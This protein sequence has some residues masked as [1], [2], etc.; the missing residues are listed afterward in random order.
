[1]FTY[2][3]LENF[4]SFGKIRFDFK[5]N[6]NECKKFAAI[7]GE[8]GSGKSNFVSAY[9]LL[10]M[11]M[12]SY[13]NKERKLKALQ[14]LST[15]SSRSSNFLNKVLLQ[16]INIDD[17]DVNF[18]KYRMLGCSENT[19]IKYGFIIN[20]VEGYYS[21][22][23]DDYSILKEEL[24]YI[25]NKQRG[26]LFDIK[27]CGEE[28]NSHISK[29]LF[30]DSKLEE[31]IFKN[32]EMY[33]GKNTLLALLIKEK[34]DKNPEY[35]N[36]NISKNLISVVNFFMHIYI[37]C[38]PSP[39]SRTN[40]I[41][42]SN[43]KIRDLSKVYIEPQNEKQKKYLKK[44]EKI[45]KDFFTQAY[46][47]IIDVYYDMN[48][49]NQDDEDMYEYVPYVKKIIAGEVRTIPFDLE[50]AGTQS[51]LKVLRA[52]IEAICGNVVIYDEIDEGIHDLLMKNILMSLQDEIEGQLI[53]TTHNTLL[54]EDLDFKSAYVIYTDYDGNK[55]ARCLADYDVRIQPSNNKMR[56]YLNGI[57]GGVPYSSEIDYSKMHIDNSD[58]EE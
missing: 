49:E 53:I 14:S 57:F 27:K 23:F 48:V 52:I 47:D 16:K 45:I 19:N 42:G 50:S 43:I 54:L 31:D 1:M 7:Y 33:W 6:K 3:E 8:N 29:Y 21:I 30:N 25:N 26:I 34:I 55:E 36:N 41:S 22:S 51:V 2:I 46:S 56:L 18:K 20:G 13:I 40:I 5:K 11:L 12:T 32:I 9:E 44:M 37:L 39:Y 58:M 10:S 28:I 24:Y 17:F 4:K 35:I 15:D 38:K